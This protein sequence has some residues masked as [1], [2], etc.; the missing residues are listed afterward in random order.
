MFSLLATFHFLRPGWL[1]AIVP[2]AILWWILW[3]RSDISQKWTKWMNPVLLKA[4]L[5][6]ESESKKPGPI[7][8]L[9][10]VWLLFII[11]LAGPSW[12]REKPP[13]AEDEAAVVIAIKVTPS[14]QASDVAPSRQERSAHKVSDLLALRPATRNALLAYAGSAHLV[15]PLTEDASII[16][17]FAGELS[18]EIMPVPGENAGAVLALAT[19]QLQRRGESG[20]IL[21][22]ADDFTPEAVE[23]ARNHRKSG[24][25]PVHVLLAN[26]IETPLAD[27]FAKAGGGST[28]LMTPDQSDVELL[29]GRLR[30]SATFSLE[31]GERWRDDGFLL[32]PLLALCGLLWFRKGWV[33]DGDG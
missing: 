1:I 3:R 31:S 8:L 5:R 18:P 25:V 30:R 14:M 16:G 13:F 7:H 19:E 20:S 33:L 9:G 26:S 6:E 22:L 4:L 24:G 23:A 11:A 29:S 15:M 21:F 12:R 32:V 2:A 17:S 10:L 27:E 28:I